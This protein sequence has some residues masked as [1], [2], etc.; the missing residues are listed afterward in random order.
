MSHESAKTYLGFDPGTQKCGL[1]IVS[2]EKSVLWRSVVSV[3]EALAKVQQLVDTYGP[4]AIVLGNQTGSLD[5]LV[6]LQ[7]LGLPINRI[8]ERYSSQQARLRYW[9]HYPAGWQGLLPRGLRVPP[10]AY[11]DLV[12]V[13]LVERYLDL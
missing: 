3:A 2:E 10:T 7:D 9:D 5:W 6:R 13:I 12:A 1:A 8:D 4:V 11:D